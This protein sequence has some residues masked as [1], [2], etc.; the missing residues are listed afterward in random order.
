MKA[1]LAL[2]VVLGI[3]VLGSA[4]TVAPGAGMKAD[5]ITRDGN[6]T[7]LKGSVTLS[8]NGPVW[9]SADEADVAESNEIELR[10]TVR[11]RTSPR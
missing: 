10:G 11:L 6:T 3:A 8:I 4:Q 9:V 2:S 5:T 7:H 1:V